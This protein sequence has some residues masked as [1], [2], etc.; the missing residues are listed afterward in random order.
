MKKVKPIA[1]NRW[2]IISRDL[3]TNEEKLYEFDAVIIANGRRSVPKY[4]HLKGIETYEGKQFHSHDYRNP[5][6]FENDQVLVIGAGAS[7]LD[8][9]FHISKAA[10]KVISTRWS[11]L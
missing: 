9:T 6:P 10:D 5:K 11:K 8:I 4:P 2:E 3:Q 7:G 1:N